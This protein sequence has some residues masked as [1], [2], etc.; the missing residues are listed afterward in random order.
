M[1]GLFAS[2]LR[3]GDIAIDVGAN[4]GW[5]T[6][7]SAALVGPEGKVF[8]FEPA[9]ENQDVIE[10]H[11]KM[12]SLTNV[13]LVKSAVSDKEGTQDFYLNPYGNGGHSFYNMQAGREDLKQPEVVQVN[14]VTLDKYLENTDWSKIRLMKIDTEGHD[15]RVLAGARNLLEYHVPYIFSELHGGI[16][17]FNDTQLGFYSM[18]REYGYQPF[19][20]FK[21]MALPVMLPPGAQIKSRC[22]LNLLYAT[23]ENIAALCPVIEVSCGEEK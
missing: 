13:E 23:P 9:K 17:M 11:I 1:S 10:E 15:V 2:I 22:A 5:F 7:L 4:V 8:S 19:L 3:P 21:E 18:M 16:K 14:K 6:V 20:L 12:N